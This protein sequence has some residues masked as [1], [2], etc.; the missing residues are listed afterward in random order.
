VKLHEK[1]KKVAAERRE[2][3]KAKTLAEAEVLELKKKKDVNFERMKKLQEEVTMM[4]MMM[5]LMM[6]MF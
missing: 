4:M 6:V 3:L 5:M 2:M 1:Q